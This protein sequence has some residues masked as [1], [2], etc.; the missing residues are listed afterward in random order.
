MTGPAAEPASPTG[1]TSRGP[2][3]RCA[4]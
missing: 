2:G 4:A 1:V 3:R